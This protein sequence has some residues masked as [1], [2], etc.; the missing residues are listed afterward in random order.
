VYRFYN[1]VT[2]T[3]FYTISESEKETVRSTLSYIF[4]YEGIA[5]QGSTSAG[6]GWIPMFRFFNR[7]TGAHFYTSS[8]AERDSVNA[9]LPQMA[10]EGI[11]YYVRQGTT[12]TG[13]FVDAPVAGLKYKTATRE[14]ITDASGGF[15]YDIPNE[16]I[17][18][19]VGNQSLGI[20]K[21]NAVVDV[22]CVE[23]VHAGP[24]R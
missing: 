12:F 9:R 11:A 2:G 18:F 20:A 23:R 7:L 22:F 19:S 14:G 3:H 4:Q 15:V 13:Q 5:W 10:F 16:S 17:E 24:V 1:V 8:A 6:S 21:A